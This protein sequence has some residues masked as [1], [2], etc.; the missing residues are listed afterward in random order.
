MRMSYFAIDAGGGSLILGG[1]TS[2]CLDILAGVLNGQILGFTNNSSTP[3]E[4]TESTRWRLGGAGAHPFVL[5]GS[6]DWLVNNHLRS[7]ASGGIL[8]QKFGSGTMT[9]IG[10]NI[11]NAIYSDLL[12]T[13]IIIG[14]G[15]MIWKTS[16]IVGGDA[17][18]PNI[19][20]NGALLKYDAPAG[21]CMIAGNISGTGAFQMNAGTLTLSGQNTFSGSISLSGGTL[22]AGST[23]TAGISGPLGR[24]G[25]LAFTGGTLCFS[26]NNTFDYSAR[27]SLAAG[28]AIS[29]DTAGQS[30]TFATGLNS[31]GG[32]LTKI[33]AG[34]LTLSGTSSY[35]GLTSVGGGKLVFQGPKTAPGDISVAEGATLGIVDTGTPVTPATLILGVTGGANLEFDNINSTTRA[36][37]AAGTIVNGGVTVVNI[38][39]GTFHIGNSFPLLSWT[40][41]SPPAVTLGFV[42]GAAG[43]LITN[44]NSIQLNVI[45]LTPVWTGATS[46]N[47]SD[48]NNWTTPYSDS[49]PVR[50]DDSAPGTTSVTVDAPVQPGSIAVINSNKAYN[51]TSSGQNNIAGPAGLTKS[52]TGTLTLS[53]GVNTC[54]GVTTLSGGTVNVGTLANGGSPSD[55]GAASSAAAN[56][57]F[58]GG[59]LQYTGSG[60]SIDRLFTVGIGGGAIDS[61]GSG[62]LALTNPGPVSLAGSLTLSGNNTDPDT[63]AVALINSG[64][65]NKTGI[66]TWILTGTNSYGGGTT[67]ANGSLQ[68]GAG[69]STGSLGSGNVTNNSI[70]T[71]NRSGILTVS[72]SISGSGVVTNNGPG[73]VILAG[74]NTYTNGTIINAGTLQV[75]NG[76]AGGSLYA[77]GPIINNSLLVFN[78]AGSFIYN[79]GGLISGTGNLI[80]Q[81]GGVI[82]TIGNNSYTGWTR[83]DPGTTFQP[84]EGQEGLLVSLSVTN[85]GTLR[86]TSQDAAFTYGGPIVGT[87]KVQIGANNLNVGVIT[88]TGTNTYLG[89]TFIGDNQL[90]LGEGITP[91]AGTI[92]G[93]VIFA[94]NFT[95]PQDNP[96]IITFNRPDDFT[97][98]GTITTNFATPQFNRGIVRQNGTGTLTLTGNNSY[99]GGTEVNGGFLVIGNGGPSGSVGFG[100]VAF[101]SGNPLIINRSGNLTIWGN[102]SG[103]SD[104]VVK[105]GGTVTF[106]GANDTYFGL[107]SVSNGT[108]IVNGLNETSSTHVYVG[109][110]GGDGE[111]TGP[112]TM[113][114]GTTL[115]PGASLGTLTCD[116]DLTIGGNL[117]IEVNCSVSPSNDLVVVGGVLSNSAPG[118]LTVKN[119]GSTPLQVGDKFTVFSRPLLNGAVISVI[120]ARATWINN[121]AVD[122]SIYVATVVP[123][124]TL[125][126]TQA[127]NNLQFSW[128][129]G[130]NS[131][132][133]QAQTNR[134]NAGL[135]TIWSDYPGGGTSPITVVIDA[136][137]GATFF[138]LCLNAMN[139]RPPKTECLPL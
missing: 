31:G 98:G 108:L 122:G 29:I 61:S 16:D 34:T 14:G 90:V 44:G 126:F 63:L 127:G 35:D 69:G 111:F 38:N 83:I 53:G 4:I 93:N 106:N 82:K 59:G 9:W 23:E 100:P 21:A 28:Q 20:H 94:D 57:I 118:T 101:N 81:G 134:F 26:P 116:S 66:G 51:I 117:V 2:N 73:T 67:I 42:A 130:L 3:S 70:L 15:T 18:N 74:N 139:C 62:P 87:G 1:H 115:S 129:D 39:S 120:G 75:G 7:A 119:L 60:T 40:S 19:I 55:I 78:T 54:F 17:G 22:T 86:I 27:F 84:H 37:L 125:T 137:N 33:G 6:G 30:V 10:T 97:F 79:G 92:A 36:P 11:P 123:P 135:G 131:F 136:A 132:K 5:A 77:N 58:N 46:G 64:G 76:G 99:A 89:G 138:R 91:G 103:L 121:L 32:T 72:G 71:F 102:I 113:E 110:L 45:S 124:P 96:R 24:G 52:G 105:G 12:G 107:T 13:P 114:P 41:G 68:A 8:V 48:P 80:V 95:T 112:M 133:L 128:S 25:I 65:L 43:N 104:I 88:L 49:K 109:G 56:L 85:N 47:W 50:F